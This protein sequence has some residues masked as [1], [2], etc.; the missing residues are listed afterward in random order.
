MITICRFTLITVITFLH[1]GHTFCQPENFLMTC[2]SEGDTVIYIQTP[3]SFVPICDDPEEIRYLPIALH[4]ILLESPIIDTIQDC[5]SE[6]APDQY[7]IT[8]GNF[9]ATSDGLGNTNY[10][11]FQR[12]E[13]IVQKAN[14]ELENNSVQWRK[15]QSLPGSHYSPAPSNNIRYL[16]AG[17][18]FHH[19]SDFYYH[20]RNKMFVYHPVYNIDGTSVIDVYLA[21]NDPSGVAGNIGGTNKFV[22]IQNWNTYA[23]PGC[24]NWSLEYAAELLNHEIGHTLSLIHTWDDNDNCNDT[25]MGYEY[26]SGKFANCW[27]L[28]T[29]PPYCNYWPNISNNI[30]DYNQYYPHAYTL[31]QIG[32]INDNLP[33]PEGIVISILVMA[34]CL[35]WPSF[36]PMSNI[37]Y[38]NR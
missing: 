5:I 27:S 3:E 21:P 23:Q 6:G 24:Q 32:R 11:G 16:L 26:E 29:N 18:Y 20:P 25:P 9:T 31:C 4:F 8:Y 37:P 35:H 28:S 7:I 17:V 13:D 33:V 38:A 34:V 10:N 14:N 19:N 1:L 15:N 2:G 22:H 12:A 30:M 36:T